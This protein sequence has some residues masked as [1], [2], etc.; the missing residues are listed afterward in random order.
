MLVFLA[1]MGCAKTQTTQQ[2][3]PNVILIL[4]DDMGYSDL[5]SY[6]SEIKTP[7]LDQLANNGLRMTQ[8]Y[9][10]SRC[11][12]TRASLLTGLYPHQA[13][14]GFM[15][16]DC[17][18]PGYGGVIT[19]S[20]VTI[21]QALKT[22]GYNTAM[23]GKWHVGNDEA[24]WPT[25]KGFDKF[26]GFPHHGGA[27]FFPFPGDQVLMYGDSVIENPGSDYYS[28]EAI[29]EFGAEFVTDLAKEEEPFF[30]YLAHVAPH[31][32]L[33]A[34]DEDIAKYR[35]TY[36]KGFEAVRQA[37]FE[38]M[39]AQGIIPEDYP[40]SQ[41]DEKVPDWDELSEEEKD[42]YD[43]RMSIYAAQIET[44]DRGIGDLVKQLETIGELD[45][46]VIIFLSDNGGTREDYSWGDSTIQLG[47]QGSF[48]C[49]KLPW[50]NVSNTPYRMFKHWG[51]EGGIRT[52][53]IVHYPNL[54]KEPR[55]DNQPAH[56]IDVMTTILEL[57]ASK[58]PTTYNGNQIQALEG[59]SLLPIFSKKTRDAHEGLFWEHEGNKAARIGDWKWVSAYPAYVEEL[60]DL[61]TDP[62]ESKNLAEANP[63]Q[64][65]E[66]KTKWKLWA[67]RVG[68][69][70][71]DSVLR[72]EPK[73]ARL[74]IYY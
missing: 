41:P 35:G 66:M 54:I 69:L 16:E 56:I 22:N 5:G 13:N 62:T 70:P 48:G 65:A 38:K 26:Y 45:N 27:Y 19:N 17:K 57:T 50:A 39:K 9:N 14:M 73:Q 7:A 32:P 33:Q 36:K 18:V 6:G 40:I 58:Y 47:K 74:Q 53:F 31:F 49:Y 61:S 51:N 71:W 4:A 60:Y 42:D 52:P 3:R 23:S 64:L 12:P 11:C 44:M 20:A 46:T 37:R 2:E 29:N 24:Y 10:A 72:A 8:F 68:V 63:H 43:L 28:T 55:I 15:Q 25:Q 1:C 34:R 59:K 21:A 30:L 67:D